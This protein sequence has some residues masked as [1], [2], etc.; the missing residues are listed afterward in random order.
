MTQTS[1]DFPTLDALERELT[2]AAHRQHEQ[3][4]TPR[5]KRRKRWRIGVLA[6]VGAL[7]VAGGATA[8]NLISLGSP[9]DDPSKIPASLRPAE[10]LTGRPITLTAPDADAS[11]KWGAVA[12]TNRAGAPCVLAGWVRGSSLGV[13]EDGRFRPY[14]SLRSGLCGSDGPDSVS[15][16]T[17]NVTE[18]KSRTLVFGRAAE[19]IDAVEL[20]DGAKTHRVP[21]GSDG[22]YLAVLDGR[23]P[24]QR[25]SVVPSARTAPRKP[26][27]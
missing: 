20:N 27:G 19:T 16:S 9:D 11:G 14:T 7:A 22:A 15:L 12:Y 18:P 6:G 21:T 23:V 3:A 2:D 10:P 26:Q 24:P 17:L 8:T 13:V 5:R 25:L 1:D 4:S